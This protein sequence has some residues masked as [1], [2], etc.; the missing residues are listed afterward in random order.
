[1]YGLHSPSL[2]TAR[3]QSIVS[4]V[5]V[6]VEG[7]G[8]LARAAAYIREC[9]KRRSLA[10]D[11]FPCHSDKVPPDKSLD[12]IGKEMKANILHALPVSRPEEDIESNRRSDER[13]IE[14][15]EASEMSGSPAL[16]E[17]Q[18]SSPEPFL[19]DWET[20][21][22]GVTCVDVLRE[23]SAAKEADD[24]AASCRN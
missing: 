21:Q 2:K 7:E 1:M 16:A 15:D 6:S 14:A 24:A 8:Q 5:P 20:V 22:N 11:E 23:A 18:K 3:K 4:C 19:Y 17:K 10:S 9:I 13:L 12:V